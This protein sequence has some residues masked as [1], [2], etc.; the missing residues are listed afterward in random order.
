MS[1]AA[2]WPAGVRVVVATL[3]LTVA[4]TVGPAIQQAGA[5]D[6]FWTKDTTHYQSP[7]FEGRH[8]IMIPFGCTRAP[9]YAPDPRCSRDRGFHHG[10]DVAMACGTRLFSNVRGRVVGRTAPGA[11]GAAYG[12]LAFRIRARSVDYVFGHVRRVFVQPGDRVTRGQLIARAGA[13]GAP[14]GCHLHFEVRPHG[15]GYTSARPPRAYLHLT[16]TTA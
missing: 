15:G 7:W 9:Y 14:D 11:P 5:Q 2:R 13:L 10:I 12:V 1:N 3:I 8:R 16:A 4:A 6:R